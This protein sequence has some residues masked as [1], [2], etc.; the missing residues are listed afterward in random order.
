MRKM[1][2]LV[3]LVVLCSSL[4]FGALDYSVIDPGCLPT[5]TGSL[6]D[7]E[8]RIVYTDASGLYIL[9]EYQGVLHI[10]YI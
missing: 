3:M 1:T 4:L 10:V 5:Y 6:C 9:I 8:I 7:P 2:L